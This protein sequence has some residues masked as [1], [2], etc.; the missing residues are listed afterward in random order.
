M[1][2]DDVCFFMFSLFGLF[3]FF[4]VGQG[5]RNNSLSVKSPAHKIIALTSQTGLLVRVKPIGSV[6]LEP[7]SHVK[8]VCFM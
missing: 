7:P 3:L 6:A 4:V 1:L 5:P 8:F 2:R